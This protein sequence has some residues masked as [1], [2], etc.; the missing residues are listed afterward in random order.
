MLRMQIYTENKKMIE[1]HN[2][3]FAEGLES[4]SVQINQF[5]DM[6]DEEFRELLLGLDTT[7]GELVGSTFL[8][9]ENADDIPESVDWRQR[10]AVT[11]V[12][13]QGLCGSCWAFS[14]TGALEAQT[15]RKTK[16]LIS[17]SDQN[18]LDCTSY[19]GYGNSGCEGG[20]MNNAYRYILD[21]GG[22]DT[23]Q[24]Y[25]YE[26]SLEDCR[27]NNS[28]VGASMTSFVT[29]SPGDEEELKQALAT[30]G[31]VSAGMDASILGFRYYKSGI[32]YDEDCSN[33]RL[34]HA[35]LIV[36]YGSEDG[37]DYWLVKNSWGPKWGDHG[38]F[39]ITRNK[40]NHCGIAG[41]T[42]YPLV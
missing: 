20:L 15:F 38:Y 31:P 6:T 37:E 5:G 42:S 32:F 9:P 1:E 14:A 8:P 4:F 7:P 22:V 27:F 40:D 36:G 2:Q 39:R 41:I 29:L 26:G 21:N 30:I 23:E 35:V 24:S 3:R 34:N 13:N 28:T 33:T 25:P 19:N 12:K 18:L 10:G 11:R 17:L 16:R